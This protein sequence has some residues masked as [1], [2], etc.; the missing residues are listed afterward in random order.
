ME[1]SARLYYAAIVVGG[2]LLARWGL[3]EL[4]S[5]D[6]TVFGVLLAVGGVGMVLATV[7]E[8]ATSEDLSATVPDDRTLWFTVGCATVGVLGLLLE[9]VA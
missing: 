5:G 4:L 6:I 9:T 8:V 1:T 2:A 7:H 3:S